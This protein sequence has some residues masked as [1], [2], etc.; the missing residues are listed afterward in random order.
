VISNHL[1]RV[2]RES[3]RAP[4]STSK[5]LG[6]VEPTEDERERMLAI[7][8]GL[9]DRFRARGELC[10]SDSEFGFAPAAFN[11]AFGTAELRW[12]SGSRAWISA[13]ISGPHRALLVWRHPSYRFGQDDQYLHDARNPAKD[14]TRTYRVVLVVHAG[15]VAEITSD[16]E[17]T[18]GYSQLSISSVETELSSEN[19]CQAC[20]LV[21]RNG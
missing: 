5:T 9:R 15:S 3:E 4:V 17:T 13:W 18:L 2:I 12:N 14:S 19:A 16:L 8:N 6:N 20:G 7:L 1:I 11:V 21:R 10:V